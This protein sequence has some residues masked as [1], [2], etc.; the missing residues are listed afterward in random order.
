MSRFRFAF[1][2]AIGLWVLIA[3]CKSYKDRDQ[4]LPDTNGRGVIRVSAD[5]SFKPVID[6]MVKVYESN[7]VGTRI[8]VTYKPEAECLK[9]MLNDS[10]TMII[11]TRF[12]SAGEKRLISDS[13]KVQLHGMLIARD[14]IAVIMS[15]SSE[16]SYFTNQEVK[17]ILQGKFKN[18]LIPVFDGVKATST[19]R[20]IIDSVLHGDTLTS[21]ATAARSSEEVI[22]YISKN[23]NAVGFIGVS[24]IGNK[25]DAAQLSFLQ[26]VKIIPIQSEKFPDDFLTPVQENIFTKNY[27]MVRDLVYILKERHEGLGQGFADFMSGEKGQLIIRR[28]Y[29]VPGTMDFRIRT[30]QLHEE[31]PK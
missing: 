26:K 30:A 17:E 27:P 1:L 12:Y 7:R 24:W 28:A 6:E 9:D 16:Y 15:P 11:A 19:V 10:V 2:L 8:D 29:L 18:N 23:P 31:I 4:E 20:F 25:D 21:K 14:A 22:D 13:L 5:E 3:G